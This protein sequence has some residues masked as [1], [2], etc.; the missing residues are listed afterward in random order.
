MEPLRRGGAPVPKMRRGGRGGTQLVLT[1]VRSMEP[2]RRG[3]GPV[4]D[5]RR[6][7]IAVD[8]GSPLSSCSFSM[9]PEVTSG[10]P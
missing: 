2:L 4:P 9:V 7:P 8:E 5:M 1:C 10:A 6:E 3:G